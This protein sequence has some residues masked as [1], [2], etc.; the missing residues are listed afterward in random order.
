MLILARGGQLTEAHFW[1]SGP[2]SGQL[3]PQILLPLPGP[4][5]DCACSV[6]PTL[7]TEPGTSGVVWG[8]ARPFTTCA[9]L[10]VQLPW[11]KSFAFHR[12]IYPSSSEGEGRCG[13]GWDKH[14]CSDGEQ[15]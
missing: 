4:Y 14:P 9:F 11:G 15:Q 12:I 10:L 5:Q 2:V 13:M 3:A 8:A 7:S 1:G 6:D